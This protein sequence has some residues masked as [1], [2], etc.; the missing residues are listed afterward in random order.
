MFLAHTVYL[1]S[2]LERVRISGSAVLSQSSSFVVDQT[3]LP[4]RQP[5]YSQDFQIE[6][7]YSISSSSR[8]P[9]G[10]SDFIMNAIGENTEE[11]Q[12]RTPL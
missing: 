7:T 9:A 2:A 12:S 1:I 10:S 11:M 4:Q 3:Q 8:V 6:A 5:G